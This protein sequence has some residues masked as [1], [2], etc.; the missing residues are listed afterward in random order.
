MRDYFRNLF[1][2][3]PELF[4]LSVPCVCN[5]F[6]STP[7]SY[8]NE[9]LL[10]WLSLFAQVL[11]L[12]G[13]YLSIAFLTAVPRGGDRRSHLWGDPDTSFWN[14]R[15]AMSSLLC[16][17]GSSLLASVGEPRDQRLPHHSPEDS[18]FVVYPVSHAGPTPIDTGHFFLI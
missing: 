7:Q 6:C 2:W 11:H 18:I 17:L 3:L 12:Q 16:P 1:V 9:L 4:A 8:K 14:S 13:P 10:L 15:L 5:C